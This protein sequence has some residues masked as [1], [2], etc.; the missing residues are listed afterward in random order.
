M[1]LKEDLYPQS[2]AES[3]S[4]NLKQ[5][6]RFLWKYISNRIPFFRSHN[7]DL[8]DFAVLSLF[9]LLLELIHIEIFLFCS[10]CC[11]SLF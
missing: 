2:A 3:L 9:T 11:A 10:L 7:E 6:I 4:P 1:S 5:Q 8:C